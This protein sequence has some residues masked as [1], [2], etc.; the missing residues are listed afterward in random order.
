MEHATS[1]PV[2]RIKDGGV[3]PPLDDGEPVW[4]GYQFHAW[5]YEC[6][7]YFF[8]DLD[9]VGCVYIFA[10]CDDR[11]FWFPHYIGKTRCLKSR[12]RWPDNQ[13]LPRHQMW[14]HAAIL[15]ATHVHTHDIY[16]AG[17]RDLLEHWLIYRYQPSLNIRRRSYP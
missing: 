17:A 16:D 8:R 15:G 1:A 12:L 5:E 13:T 2:W 7:H 4:D 11:G 10:S 6:E 9:G 3:L 14:R